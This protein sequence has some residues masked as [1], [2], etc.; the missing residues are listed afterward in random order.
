MPLSAAQMDSVL[1]VWHTR[2]YASAC[3]A[4]AQVQIETSPAVSEAEEL[5]GHYSLIP[6]KDMN[7]RETS[8]PH[9]SQ[10]WR[11]GASSTRLGGSLHRVELRNDAI[12]PRQT[13]HRPNRP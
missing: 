13:C 8:R 2:L 9:F 1:E 3:S 6:L 11:V 5:A 4:A 10:M 12:Y 7:A